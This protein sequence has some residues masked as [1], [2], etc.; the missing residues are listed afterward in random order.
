MAQRF[1]LGRGAG[2][3][4]AFEALDGEVGAAFEWA[5][6]LQQ[7]GVGLQRIQRRVQG[8]WQAVNAAPLALVVAQVAGVHVYWRAGVAPLADAVQPGGD[9][10]AERQIGVAAVV[11][12]LQLEVGGFRL[13]APERRRNADRAFAI[14]EAVG[15]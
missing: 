8:L 2:A 1:L 14:V 4:G 3:G 5:E 6:R 7:Y 12:R 13:A 15:G 10:P 11:G 9:Q